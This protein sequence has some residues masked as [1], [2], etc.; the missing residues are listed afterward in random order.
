[1]S[2]TAYVFVEKQVKY[3]GI[4]FGEKNKTTKKTKQTHLELCSMSPV[5]FLMC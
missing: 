4:L 1:M 2:T 3:H 5:S